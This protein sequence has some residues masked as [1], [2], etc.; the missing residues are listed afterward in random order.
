MKTY[1]SSGLNIGREQEES[2]QCY[3][4]WLAFITHLPS[5]SDTLY[6]HLYRAYLN[7]TRN[8]VNFTKSCDLPAN[9]ILIM[10]HRQ[11]SLRTEKTWFGN[12]QFISFGLNKR[13]KKFGFRR[14]HDNETSSYMLLSW[15]LVLGIVFFYTGKSNFGIFYFGTLLNRYTIVYILI[16][17]HR[18]S[19]IKT[20][21]SNISNIW[22][23]DWTHYEQEETEQTEEPQLYAQF[24]FITQC[25]FP[26]ATCKANKKKNHHG[27]VACRP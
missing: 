18:C 17:C 8:S 20:L 10:S 2:H 14:I 22:T 25:S 6:T 23:A 19:M 5:Q 11:W 1:C 3:V 7:S 9:K 16:L 4:N 13:D 26:W 15:G 12:L 21:G 27:K 24:S